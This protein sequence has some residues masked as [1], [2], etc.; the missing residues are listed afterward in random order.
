[1]DKIPVS[2]VVVTFNEELFLEKCLKSIS[3][4]EEVIVIDLG[5][6]D[7][8]VEIAQKY[9]TKIILHKRVPVVEII[10]AK[11]KEFVKYDWVLITDPD[12]VTD[13]TLAEQIINLYNNKLQQST[14]IGAVV[15]PWQFY[16]KNQILKGTIWGNINRRIFLVNL[17]RFIFSKGVHVGRRLV[18]GY[19]GYN[20]KYENKNVVHHYWMSSYK[21]LIEKHKRYLKQEGQTRYENGARINLR[22]ILKTPYRAFKLCFYTKKGYKDRIIGFFL[23]IFWVWYSVSAEISL[24]KFQ[25]SKR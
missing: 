25:K 18:E 5:S 17:N 1:M 10:H 12:E 20:I 13:E 7:K 3:F 9:A 6:T 4:C 11:I 23:S 2:A 21:Q 24:Y 19:K 14:K 8:S 16:F 15:V 22:S